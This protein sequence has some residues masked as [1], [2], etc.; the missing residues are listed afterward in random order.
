MIRYIAD[1]GK[2]YRDGWPYFGPQMPQAEKI[3][4]ELANALDAANA[5]NARL[6]GAALVLRRR[7]LRLSPDAKTDDVDAAIVGSKGDAK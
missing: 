5:E 6:R 1:T 3:I 4:N 7:L 2:V